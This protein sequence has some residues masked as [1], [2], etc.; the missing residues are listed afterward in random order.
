MRPITERLSPVIKFLVVANALLFAFYL[1]VRPARPFFDLH[2][3]LTTATVLRGEFWQP[4]T[5]LFVHTDFINF[6]FNL[7]GLWWVG[8]TIERQVG[9]R[10]FLTIFFVSGLVANLIMVLLL[11]RAGLG[12][13]GAGCGSAV[14]AV[15]ISYGTIFDRTPSR[16][17]GSL[18]MEARTFTF[19]LNGFVVL[20]DVTSL[21]WANLAAHV[22]AMLL[23]Y[24]M[25]GGRGRGLA[26]LWAGL[27][28]KQVRRRYQV[29]EG[30]RRGKGPQDLN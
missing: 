30:G 16:I 3:V 18:V 7:L 1:V 8:S 11:A 26:H 22:A 24:V 20:V 19:I 21:A 28:A 25:V 12:P 9:T 4:L 15:Y 17:W 10:R 27:R 2:L 13:V 14:L 5:S 29:L 6:F 23:G